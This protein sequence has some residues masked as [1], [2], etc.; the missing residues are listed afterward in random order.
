MKGDGT[1][2]MTAQDMGKLKLSGSHVS[3]RA[4]LSGVVTQ[5]TSREALGLIWALLGTGAA[6][7]CCAA[8]SVYI[9]SA[10]RYFEH[11]YDAWLKGGESRAA[12]HRAA[13]LALRAESRPFA[14]PYH[15][16]PFSLT[17]GTAE[18]DVV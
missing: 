4:C 6:S 7:L 2:W 8:W 1:A 18:G 5:I 12:A 13:C 11:F 14:H 10:R 9:P 17:I 3:M 16:A 15:W